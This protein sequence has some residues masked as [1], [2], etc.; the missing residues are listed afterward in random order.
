MNPEKILLLNPIY[1]KMDLD[2][3]KNTS[4]SNIEYINLLLDILSKDIPFKKRDIVHYIN[5]IKENT[6]QLDNK[7][8][9]TFLNLENDKHTVELDLN[10]YHSLRLFYDN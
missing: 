5:T 10:F 2:D 6:I 3:L 4:N 8:N 9:M 1:I 7:I